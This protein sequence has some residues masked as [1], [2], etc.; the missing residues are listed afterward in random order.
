MSVILVRSDLAV[1][2]ILKGP[3]SFF[4]IQSVLPVVLSVYYFP[5]HKQC[6]PGESIFYFAPIQWLMQEIK[7]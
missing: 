7:D 6:I 4:A 5:E 2:E 1:T 3:E